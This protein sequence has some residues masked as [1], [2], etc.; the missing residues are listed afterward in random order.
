MRLHLQNVPLGPPTHRTT[1]TKHTQ[2]TL[3]RVL[4]QEQD[5]RLTKGPARWLCV[6]KGRCMYPPLWGFPELGDREERGREPPTP[7]AKGTFVRMRTHCLGNILHGVRPQPAPFQSKGR[8]WWRAHSQAGL[9]QG[10]GMTGGG[11]S[12]PGGL[13]QELEP[14]RLG[15]TPLPHHI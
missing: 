7:K 10:R 5:R 3:V 4:T 11:N 2:A 1:S 9:T 15:L 14:S 6:H 12:C 13:T 8:G